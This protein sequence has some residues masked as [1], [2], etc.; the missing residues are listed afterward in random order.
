MY[1]AYVAMDELRLKAI[2]VGHRDDLAGSDR[3]SI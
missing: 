2:I 3:G 1:A